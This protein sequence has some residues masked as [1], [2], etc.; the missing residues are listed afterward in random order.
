MEEIM[1]KILLLA[2]VAMML[3][4]VVSF[5]G[6][7]PKV[8]EVQEDATEEVV[9]TEEVPVDEAAVPVEETVTE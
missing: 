5:T 9:P 1:K 6:C 8:E 7:K 3:I 2:L 4:S